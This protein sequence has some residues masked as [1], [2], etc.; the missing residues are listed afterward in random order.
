MGTI[1]G[2]FDVQD[3][4]AAE[5]AAVQEVAARIPPEMANADG[6]GAQR[7]W[8]HRRF[9]APSYAWGYCPNRRDIWVNP[10]K[11]PAT[12][13]HVIAHEYMHGFHGRR[14]RSMDLAAMRAL[15][16]GPIGNVQTGSYTNRFSEAI[17][18]AF[19]RSIGFAAGSV[20]ARYYRARIPDANL[21][22]F[23]SLLS[24]A[25]AGPDRRPTHTF[26]RSG[27][28]ALRQAPHPEAPAVAWAAAGSVILVVAGPSGEPYRVAAA[29]AGFRSRLWLEVDALDGRLLETP[30]FTAALLWAPL[31]AL[32][33]PA[34]STPS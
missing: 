28:V 23:G 20:P 4:G 30:L 7:L 3:G 15:V 8:F 27:Q 9:G 12:V 17:A 22:A 29:G 2:V 19:A 24:K 14:R 13:R 1:V 6:R 32:S 33:S 18:D 10:A 21:G 31:P 25:E 34:P 11:P 26:L 16:V 5:L